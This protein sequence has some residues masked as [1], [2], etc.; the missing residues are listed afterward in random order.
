MPTTCLVVNCSSRSNRDEVRFFAVPAVLTN[1]FLTDKNDLSVERRKLWLA[2]LKR[3]DLTESKLKN[4]KVC[5]K[6]FLL[7]KYCKYQQNTK[8]K[9]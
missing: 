8:L 5:S 6:H 4:Q 1:R 3:E 2:A 7:G 9:S